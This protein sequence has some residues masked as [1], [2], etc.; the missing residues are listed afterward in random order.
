MR[1]NIGH[2][3]HHGSDTPTSARAILHHTDQ[4]GPNILKG[5]V[6]TA[7]MFF[8]KHF[9]PVVQM[10]PTYSR[11]D[12]KLIKVVVVP[13]PYQALRLV[14]VLLSIF[15]QN[16]PC[17]KVKMKGIKQ[18]QFQFHFLGLLGTSPM[19]KQETIFFFIIGLRR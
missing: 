9:K 5:S 11:K 8:H 1:H 7:N 12:E 3:N 4:K 19:S 2:S 15:Y 18:S 16:S 14:H 6:C 10:P 17:P 13:I